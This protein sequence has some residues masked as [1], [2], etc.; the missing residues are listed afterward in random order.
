MRP[1]AVRQAHTHG[2]QG[3]PSGRDAPEVREHHLQVPP[4]PVPVG[5]QGGRGPERGGAQGR[6][7]GVREREGAAQ[8]HGHGFRVQPQ[9]ERAGHR[10]GAGQHRQE[11]QPDVVGGSDQGDHP[12][13]RSTAAGSVVG[14]RHVCECSLLTFPNIN[15][16]ESEKFTY[17]SQRIFGGF[18]NFSNHC[19]TDQ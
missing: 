14:G 3:R 12:G 19:S 16:S 7:G 17:I 4:A 6:L 15:S 9:G 18:I 13:A 2:A 10:D 1:G 11:G 8:E 5:E